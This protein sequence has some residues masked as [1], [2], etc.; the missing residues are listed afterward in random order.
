MKSKTGIRLSNSTSSSDSVSKTYVETFID[1]TE[2]NN[3]TIIRNNKNNN[4]NNKDLLNIRKATINE[5]PI[6]LKDVTNKKY[7]DN[8]VVDFIK[9]EINNNDHVVFTD[10]D[11][12]EYK[13]YKYVPKKSITNIT[14]F[15]KTNN[16]T[17]S[18]LRYYSD[19]PLIDSIFVNRGSGT[20]HSWL[21]GL[22]VLYENLGFL[23]I[24][25]HFVGVN[26]VVELIYNDIFN[27]SEKEIV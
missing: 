26:D 14:I 8:K 5:D 4:M 13:L 17:S 24:N 1:P 16:N 21:T 2:L 27:V 11:Q 23:G 6:D 3:N 12:N 22:S 20:P 10:S 9:R 15:N 7:V 18:N 25:A 19:S